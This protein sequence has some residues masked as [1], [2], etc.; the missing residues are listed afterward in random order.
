M[1]KT[2]HV[3]LGERSYDVTVGP[4]GMDTLV[5]VLARLEPTRVIVVTET[6][7]GPNCGALLTHL[8][9]EQGIVPEIVVFEAGEV[10]KTLDTASMVLDQ[11]LTAEPAIDRK[12]VVVALGGGVAGDIAGFV[13]AVTLRGLRWV[14]CPTSLLA[15][16]DASVG[17]KTGVDHASGK[18][19]I[20]AFHQPSAVCIDVE[21]L[22]TLPLEHLRNG[23]A[24]CVKH[25][26]I[27][28]ADLLEWIAE[29]ADSLTMWDYDDEELAFDA[30]EMT[31]LIARNVAIKA[32]VVSADEKEAGERAHLN[33]GHTVGHAFETA[34]GYEQC[35]HGQAVSLG[36]IAANEIAVR[37]GLLGVACRDRVRAALEALQLPV[38]LPAD[39]DAA[40]IWS[41]M[42]H[43]KKN[44]GG[45]VRM[46][47]ASRIGEVDIYDDI[48]EAEVSA[49]VNDMKS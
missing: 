39:V 42:Q 31:E 28:D 46:V 13:A 36:M 44:R 25:A 4:D 8:L 6:N 23:L 35:L 29:R 43:D 5:E 10:H 18:N 24:E 17:G 30:T 21:S 3:D 2:I 40:E 15:D 33:F 12:A 32:A 20:G 27:R 47:L 45:K 37:R 38:T 19:L 26:V 1:N 9:D 22:R 16:V 14:Q 41:I 11:I 48:T 49:V 34:I 7:V